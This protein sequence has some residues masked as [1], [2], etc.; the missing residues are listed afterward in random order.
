MRELKKRGRGT[1]RWTN[2]VLP[3]RL[4]GFSPSYVSSVG[5]DNIYNL[6]CFLVVE[7]LDDYF[8]T[9]LLNGTHLPESKSRESGCTHQSVFEER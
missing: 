8:V 7:A 3:D 2:L 6:F 1:L 4:V 5:L 9:Y